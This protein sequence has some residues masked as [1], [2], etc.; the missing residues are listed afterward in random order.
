MVYLSACIAQIF[1]EVFI[2]ETLE[3]VWL[4]YV[5]PMLA[6]R[7]VVAAHRVL[8][9]LVAQFCKAGSLHA[10]R[11]NSCV[12]NSP[13][14][15]FVSTNVAK[16]FPS[17]MESI[18]IQSHYSY[19]PG[20]SATMWRRTRWQR[21]LDSL[22]VHQRGNFLVRYSAMAS[23]TVLT[24]LEYGATVPYLV[25][26]MFVRSCLSWCRASFWHSIW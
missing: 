8:M 21:Y 18:I 23:L 5:V 15:L 22:Q 14:F 16:A 7:E 17:F 12:L 25:Q 6:S 2:N 26:K 19:L 10:V 4:H 11:D 24:L 3:C 9:D 1:I 20:E 13:D